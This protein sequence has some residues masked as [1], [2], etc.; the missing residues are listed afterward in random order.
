MARFL[1]TVAVTVGIWGLGGGFFGGAVLLL[2]TSIW[3]VTPL[4]AFIS[5]N[6]GSLIL[7]L[8]VSYAGE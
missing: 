6:I 7:S 8:I 1:A 4:S 3:P 2:S 5:A